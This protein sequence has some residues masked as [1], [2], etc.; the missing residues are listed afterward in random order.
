[1]R[2]SQGRREERKKGGHLL[3]DAQIEVNKEDELVVVA[4]RLP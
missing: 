1:V 3:S 2:E 4:I